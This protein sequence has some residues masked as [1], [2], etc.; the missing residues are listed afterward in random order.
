[1]KSFHPRYTNSGSAMTELILQ[2]LRLHGSLLESGGLL[3]RPLGLTAA[4]WQ[5]M[6]CVASAPQPS[7]VAHIAR[8]MGLSRQSVQRLTD[9]LAGE[10]LIEY[11]ENPNHK[12]AS[13]VILT[14][15]G[16]A[17]FEAAARRQ[18]GWANALAAGLRTEDIA[19]AAAVLG[20]L[21]RRLRKRDGDSAHRAKAR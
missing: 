8:E 7:P 3:V 11:G 18:V 13:L 20:E 2:I 4:R 5:V 15:K 12:R 6:R 9:H 19:V 1:M 10:G 17:A 14:A 21:E 16:K